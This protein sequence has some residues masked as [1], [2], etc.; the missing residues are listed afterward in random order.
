MAM[1]I[2]E[3]DVIRFAEKNNLLNGDVN[4]HILKSILALGTMQGAINNMDEHAMKLAFGDALIGMIF[5]AAE[6]DLDLIKSLEL[7][8]EKVKRKNG[9]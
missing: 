7:S 5:A 6:L 2:I 9:N 3:M 8:F 1:G 4:S